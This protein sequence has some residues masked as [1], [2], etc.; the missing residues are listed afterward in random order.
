MELVVSLI[1]ERRTGI[2]STPLAHDVVFS[3]VR[4]AW[5]TSVVQ[6]EIDRR[7]LLVTCA[8]ADRITKTMITR[9]AVEK[10]SSSIG[11]NHSIGWWWRLGLRVVKA[12]H[13][14]Y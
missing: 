6:D 9:M 5:F 8:R 13:A 4:R 11:I 12:G 2:E 10:R 1:Q 14:V 3:D 7:W